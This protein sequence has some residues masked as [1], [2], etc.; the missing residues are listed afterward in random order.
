MVKPI[1]L[2]KLPNNV[3]S[4]IK[5]NWDLCRDI[6]AE[7]EIKYPEYY[8]IILLHLNEET[9]FTLQVFHEKDWTDIQQSQLKELIEKSLENIHK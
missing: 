8:W 5:S 7:Y 1:A 3:L 2:L 9:E 6:M 4:H